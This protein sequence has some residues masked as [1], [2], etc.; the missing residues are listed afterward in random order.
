MRAPLFLI[1]LALSS[2]GCSDAQDY[3]EKTGVTDSAAPDAAA[4][5]ADGDA[6]TQD[7][8]V[9]EEETERYI[10]AYSWPREVGANPDLVSVLEADA[11]AIRDELKVEADDLWQSAEG[12][13]W[14]PRQ[15]SSSKEWQVVADIP[16]YLSLSGRIT[17]YSGGAHGMYG[18]Q[19]LV[20]DKSAKKAMDGIALFRSPVALEQALGSALCDSLD[21]ARETKRG[22]PVDRGGDAFFDQC[23]AVNEASVLIGSSDGKTFNRIAVYFGPYVAGPY[24][25]GDYELDFPVT[26]AV[27]DAVKPEFVQA[28]SVRR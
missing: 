3:K 6:R 28:F 26:S 16:G 5:A 2:A 7:A 1:S 23:P 8:R 13:D 17:S 20:W 4:T 19:S 22:I 10:F 11:S 12:Q 9:I 27:I 14:E 24:A 21:K 18:L 15:V 25:E